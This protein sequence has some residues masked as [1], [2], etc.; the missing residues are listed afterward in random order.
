MNSVPRSFSG[1]HRAHGRRVQTITAD[2][3]ALVDQ[4]RNRETVALLERGVAIDIDHAD[5]KTGLGGNRGKGLRHF[6]AEVAIGTVIK[7]DLHGL[8]D[9]RK[10]ARALR[11]QP[12]C[13]GCT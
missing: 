1:H 7:D 10:E 2:L 6:L 13:Q 12:V 5:D 8:E 11:G 9:N 3:R 4:Y